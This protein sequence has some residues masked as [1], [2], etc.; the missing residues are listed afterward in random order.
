MEL[1]DSKCPNC[2]AE[3]TLNREEKTAICSHC[4]SSF[5]VD[6]A[7]KKYV[8]NN[9]YNIAH[10][11][12]IKSDFSDEALE[13][14]IDKYIAQFN[15]DNYDKLTDIVE[16]LKDKF[17]HKGLARIAILHYQFTT[18]I[19]DIQGEN[20]FIDESNAIEERYNNYNPRKIRHKPPYSSFIDKLDIIEI[21]YADDLDEILTDE[22]RTSY[23]DIVNTTLD[24]IERYK[25]IV[26]YNQKI[27]EKYKPF[28]NIV[29][30]RKQK[31]ARRKQA[32]AKIK[33]YRFLVLF[34]AVI[35][36]LIFAASSFLITRNNLMAK[37]YFVKVSNV[38]RL[39]FPIKSSA[40]G[41]IPIEY[42]Q[43]SITLTKLYS[44]KITGRVAG[45]HSFMQFGTKNKLQ[46]VIIG[47]TWGD[48]SSKELTKKVDWK[49]SI[50]SEQTTYKQI[51]LDLER[52]FSSNK[53]IPADDNIRD[54]FKVIREN[55]IIQIEGFLV[56][57]LINSGDKIERI[58]TS[59][60]LDDSIYE[61][62][63][64]TNIKWISSN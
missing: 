55:D 59:T 44:Y 33:K 3:I 31:K 50:F 7:I 11:T 49:Y 8:T 2:G 52:N 10:A 39:D 47:L 56:N 18:L 48:Y 62:I 22:N 20:I 6:D 41:T 24:Y 38:N 1:I 35:T 36:A 51:G 42:G 45:K 53:L 25:K 13:N 19:I 43:T 64:V 23:D 4:N 12:I 29:E 32:V 17:P 14:E 60:V 40:T 63:Y 54:L 34:V 30:Y 57:I 15:L 9:S 21:Q 58:S 37:R 26:L 61:I 5:L 27:E 46:P 28:E 16:N